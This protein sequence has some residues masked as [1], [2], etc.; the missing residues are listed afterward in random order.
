MALRKALRCLC[1]FITNYVDRHSKRSDGNRLAVNKAARVRN[2]R[3]RHLTDKELFFKWKFFCM[4]GMAR[5]RAI[6]KRMS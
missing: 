5:P 3:H 6:K 4:L 2:P 1:S